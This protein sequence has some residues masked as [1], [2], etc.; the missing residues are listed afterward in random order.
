MKIRIL[1]TGIAIG[2]FSSVAADELT[3][4]VVAK[5]AKIETLASLM[6]ADDECPGIERVEPDFTWKFLDELTA[7]DDRDATTL[8][9]VEHFR[10]QAALWVEEDGLTPFCDGA[11]ILYG[12]TGFIEAGIIDRVSTS[13]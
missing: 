5:V 1:C 7:I 4:R 12:P 8:Y 2:I 11:Y 3:D 6:F 13:D 10:E 9:L